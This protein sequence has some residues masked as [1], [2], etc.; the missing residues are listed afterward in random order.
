MALSFFS[1]P[2]LSQ[3]RHPGRSPAHSGHYCT[4][5]KG[6]W[7]WIVTVGAVI[8]ECNYCKVVNEK[9]VAGCNVCE[10]GIRGPLD[11]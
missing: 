1:F 9:K 6:L 10:T 4:Q 11:R 2:L 3:C 7:L 8:G 5:I